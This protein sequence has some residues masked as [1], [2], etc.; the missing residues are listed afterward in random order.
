M[1]DMA[2]QDSSWGLPDPVANP[3]FYQDIPTKRFVA[4]I[5]DTVLIA[6]ICAL[7]VPFTAFTALFFLPLLYLVVGFLYRWS[8]LS[9]H[10]ATP[11][12][13]LTAIGLRTAGGHRFDGTTAG[14]HTLGYTLSMAI[15]PLQLISVVLMLTTARKQGLTDH[16]LGTAAIN[17][18]AAL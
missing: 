17:R 6:L 7:I 15:F 1:T 9:W 12:M 4:W 10:S 14:L 13:R 5:V 11:G 8:T 3:D 18:A 2:G 16:I